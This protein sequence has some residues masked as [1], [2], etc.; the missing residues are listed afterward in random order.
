MSQYPINPD[1]VAPGALSGNEQLKANSQHL[2]GTISDDLTNPVTGGFVGDNFMLI[3]F[4]GMYQQDDR[5]IRVER[6]AQKLEPLHNVMLRARLPGGIITTKQWLALEKFATA[7]TLYGSVRLTTRQTFQ[8][9]GVLKP[10]IKPTHQFL[11]SIGIDSIATAG[12]VNRN[13]LCTPNPVESELHQQAYEWAAKIS[14]HLLPKTRAY[15]EIW[16]DEEEIETTDIEPVL[17]D[18]YLPRK[19]KTAVVIP[20]NNDIDL[21]ANDLSFVAVAEH[22][23]LIGFNVLVGGG[24]AMTWGDNATYPRLA[25]ELGYI[26]LEHTLKVAEHVVTVQ[27]DYGNR[28]NRKN[29]KTK[30]TI[31]RIGLDVFRA[32]VEARTNLSFAPIKPY[33]FT[34]RG[35]RIGWVDGIDGKQHLT[36]FIENGR[37]LDFPDKPLK[38]GLAKIA[39]IHQGDFRITANQNLII[40]GVVPSQKAEIDTIA[41]AHGLIDDSHS[42]LRKNSM[43][44]VALPTCPLAMAEAERYLPDLVTKVEALLIKHNIADEHIILRVTGC[45]NSCGRTMLAEVA[46]VGRAPGKYNLYLG[47]NRE[48]TRIPRLFLDNV[49][50]TDILS[51]LDRLIGHWATERSNSNEGFGDFVIRAGV[52]TPVVVPKDDFHS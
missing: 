34:S 39:A 43:A 21:H 47:G 25:D 18:T 29:A 19:F 52:V 40:A 4:H 3:R 33:R 38:T 5:D 31:D 14:E 11:H 15:A 24:L 10:N 17:G 9:H 26:P 1:L 7:N 2:R 32:E 37:V 30:Y 23:Q 6:T 8:L 16:L 41:R 45:P 22:G 51:T 49:A 20:P 36:L 35:D 13:V 12:D 44:C 28:S 50:E 48:G 46:L 27:R 42:K